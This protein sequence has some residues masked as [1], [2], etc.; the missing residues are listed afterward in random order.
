MIP[1][2]NTANT[3]MLTHLFA[4]IPSNYSANN[5]YLYKVMPEAQTK[6]KIFRTK[7]MDRI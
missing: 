4:T 3:S 7:K 5:P 1:F 2:H 6:L